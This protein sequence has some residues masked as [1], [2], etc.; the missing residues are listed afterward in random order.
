MRFVFLKWLQKY[1][2][3]VHHFSC[4]LFLTIWSFPFC[5]NWRL[6]WFWTCRVVS[7]WPYENDPTQAAV[8]LS[9]RVHATLCNSSGL[10]F[11]RDEVNVLFPAAVLL[12][13]KNVY[14][15]LNKVRTEKPKRFLARSSKPVF[16]EFCIP[17][18]LTVPHPQRC[19]PL[20]SCPAALGWCVPGLLQHPPSGTFWCER[21]VLQCLHPDSAP[22]GDALP[23]PGLCRWCSTD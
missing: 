17:R 23:C 11:W 4:R 15:F 22:Q 10:S 20:R 7:A 3:N 5:F 8:F 14:E 21:S 19:A 16:E 6:F 9:G 18:N 1:W 13:T 12:F 2:I